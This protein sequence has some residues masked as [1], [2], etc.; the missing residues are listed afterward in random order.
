MRIAP[1]RCTWNSSVRN[2]TC[3][4]SSRI[5]PRACHPGRAWRH[6]GPGPSCPCR[7]RS[8]LPLSKFAKAAKN[9]P[10]V[11]RFPPTWR[12]AGLAWRRSF[13]PASRFHGYP[14]TTCTDCG[15]RYTVVAA[16]PYDRE[17][18]TL[19]DFPLCETCRAEYED[20]RS[21]RFHA[22]SI[23]C[24]E[25]GP[26]LRLLD[27]AGRELAGDPL[28][29]ARAALVAGKVVA[30]KGLGGF[31]LA[32]DPCRPGA[33]ARLRERKRRPHKPLA[34]MASSLDGV[35][36]HF[37]LGAR[38]AEAL[39]SPE[40]PIVLLAPRSDT[41][42][43]AVAGV[44]APD[45]GELGVMLPTTPLHALLARPLPGDPTPAFELLVMTSGNRR[46]EPICTR[47]DQALERLAGIADMWLTHD[48][49]I[50]LRCDDSV[51]AEAPGGMMLW[52]RARGFAPAAV[53]LAQPLDRTVL[54]LG[55]EMKNT[56]AL[57][58]D[59]EIVLSPHVGDLET[60]E[61]CAGLE[62]IVEALPRFL[63]REVEV[64]A[65]DLHPDMHSTRCGRRLAAEAGLEVVA[66][67]H[68]LAH[69]A[70]TMAEWGLERALAVVFDGTGM[71]SDGVIWGAEV[72]EI[73]PDG[74]W[75]RASFVPAPLPGG[76][77]AVR[78][79]GRQLLARWIDAGA[80]VPEAWWRRLGLEGDQRRV[81]EVQVARG[82][83]TP[84]THAAG[85][86]FDAYA[87]AL[88]VA[89]GSITWQAQAPARLE[90]LA[91]GHQG[92]LPGQVDFVEREEGA[93]VDR[94]DAGFP[95]LA[96]G[97]GRSRA[98]RRLGD[99]LPPGHGP[100]GD[101]PGGVRTG[102]G[103]TPWRGAHRWGDDE[104]PAGRHAGAGSRSPGCRA[105]LAAA[106]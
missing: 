33:V 63:R 27:A 20:P 43:A 70:A 37:H 74:W 45:T 25:C 5:C 95:A 40:A 105:V 31:L 106:G 86:V 18:T 36:R 22:E 35:R 56:V 15:P 50:L 51:V 1:A 44:L 12:S 19:A 7:P 93:A 85:R 84:R 89:P 61:A 49:R 52:R 98:P 73:G 96:R 103:R 67:Q 6:S 38:A 2:G 28:C 24:P 9:R 32:V 8:R 76:D 17:R 59:R 47:T 82:L 14:F 79:P 30:V 90:A 102:S 100:G 58:F 77:A 46:G 42:A 65:V 11:S 39:A 83:N 21:R 71:G 101:A 16:M 57:G 88:G 54:A 69:A 26:R 80:V 66:V 62:R 91:R 4:P 64:V 29:Q 92:P 81:F 97:A 72:L 48:R 23:A 13:D 104:P 75:R 3:G 60:P 34:V 55:A 99:G 41:V 78:H 68:H 94:L 10:I 53:G 87:A